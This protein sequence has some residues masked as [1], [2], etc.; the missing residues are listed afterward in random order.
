[1]KY[2]IVGLGNIGTEYEATRHNVGFMVVDAL[3]KSE[4]ATFST[5]RYGSIAQIK[6]K[7]R[8][9]ILLKP[10]T[11]MNLSGKAF[12]YWLQKENIPIENS[13]VVVDD[14]DLEVGVLRL[15]GSGGGGSHNG[16]NNIIEVTG[17]ESYPRLRFGI[18][19]NYTIGKQVDYV[20]GAFTA[21]D[22]DKVNP[23][24]EESIKL[25]KS[26]V[27]LGIDRTMNLFNKK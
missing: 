21:E 18:G 26:L 9:L 5:A 20:L 7:G 25:I 4:G 23:K 10:S 14:I 12:Q 8:I 16:L 27:T 19:K 15:K 22:L 3:A 2:L 13:L 6:H 17:S 11:F 24:I 1:M